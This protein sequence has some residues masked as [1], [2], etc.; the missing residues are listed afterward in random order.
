M[1]LFKPG[2]VVGQ[3][4]GR[5]GGS[6][7]SHN[8]GGAYIRNGAIPVTS[9]TADALN[10]KARLTNSSQ[11]WGALT[12]TQRLAWAV[13][14]QNTP[15]LNRLGDSRPVPANALYIALNTRLVQ[16]GQSTIS[17]PPATD[18]PAS[19]AS[20]VLSADIGTGT[21][22]ITF[23]PT[24]LGA[25]LMPRIFAAKVQ[26]DSINY[27]ADQLRLVQF[28]AAAQAS[29]LDIQT[30]VE[31]KFGPSVVGEKVVVQVDVLDTATGLVSGQLRAEALV[32]D[33]P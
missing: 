16:A 6:V 10:A 22:D 23:T 7:F 17:T 33:T 18:A 2:P 14:A 26:R 11:A 20:L 28:G 24:P 32:T 1:A 30:A 9:T 29:P 21:Y 8:K 31:A 25:G 12:A 5:V 19:L 4:S 13:F 15:L 3:V 27:V